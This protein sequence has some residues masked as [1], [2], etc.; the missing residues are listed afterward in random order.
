MSTGRGT[1]RRPASRRSGRPIAVGDT[2]RRVVG[3]CPLGIDQTKQ[4]IQTLQP[5]QCGVSVHGAT[6]L[7]GMGLQRLVDAR[8]D[9][10]GWLVLTIDMSNAF[11]TIKREAVLAGCAR[12]VPTAYNWLRSCYQGHSLL[13]C[14]GKAVLTSQTGTHQATRVVLWV[15]CSAWKRPCQR[16]DLRA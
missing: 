4:Q 15:L 2:L 8:K 9:E 13:Y 11:N 5:R 10:P 6:E 7:V 3:K 1:P 14:Q 12:R 16:P